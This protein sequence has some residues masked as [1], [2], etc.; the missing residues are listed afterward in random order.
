MCVVSY[1]SDYY[2]DRTLPNSFPAINPFQPIL[3]QVSKEEFDRLKKEFEEF[4]KLLLSAQKYD[5]AVG[6]PHCEH[7]EKVKLIKKLAL[8]L[9]VDLKGI[10]D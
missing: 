6:E 9:G 5:E 2:K 8:E 10:F 3:P 4:K 7:P 1:V